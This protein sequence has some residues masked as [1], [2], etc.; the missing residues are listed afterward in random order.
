MPILRL[1]AGWASLLFGMITLGGVLQTK[2]QQIAFNF[3]SCSQQK[4]G[5]T[6]DQWHDALNEA[7]DMATNV[8]SLA[9]S[10]DENVRL[11][12]NNLIAETAPMD[13]AP[14][15]VRATQVISKN[16]ICGCSRA[17]NS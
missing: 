14:P 17:W 15:S 10:R 11:M 1:L 13:G 9:R 16:I 6:E 5:Y 7:Y 12:W 4:T 3:T 2:A 8:L